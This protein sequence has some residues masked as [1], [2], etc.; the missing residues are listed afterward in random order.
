MGQQTTHNQPDEVRTD[1]GITNLP[2]DFEPDTGDRLG[3]REYNFEASIFEN[4]GDAVF[5]YYIDRQSLEKEDR[6]DPTKKIVHNFLIL[7]DCYYDDVYYRV[8]ETSNIKKKV[9]EFKLL[10]CEKEPR[11]VFIQYVGTSNFAGGFQYKRFNM[12][13][14]VNPDELKKYF[15]DPEREAG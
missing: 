6:N 7:K 14:D 5:G 8:K 4:N 12:K 9:E 10:P 2:L 11:T 13:V 15:L 1:R 3:I